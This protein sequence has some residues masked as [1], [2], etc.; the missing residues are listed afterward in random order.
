[1]FSGSRF[2][3]LPVRFY[4]ACLNIPL[5]GACGRL[6]CQTR[7]GLR[8]RHLLG[9][10]V[11]RGN[12]HKIAKQCDEMLRA[13][14]WLVER[15]HGS[16]FQR[17]LPDR[18]IWRR[19]AGFRWV[20]YKDASRYEYTVAQRE[21]WPTWERYGL[22]VWILTAAT[23]TEY[24]K[25]FEPPNFRHY[26]KARYDRGATPAQLIGVLNEHYRRTN[27]KTSNES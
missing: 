16:A 24:D 6:E 14:G 12:E 11:A 18:F 9:G 4:N 13:R 5:V 8:A 2:F 7:N 21:K 25:L 26:W 23:Q 1:M 20:D 22:G 27:Q 10:F 17:G 15:T 3:H 19:N